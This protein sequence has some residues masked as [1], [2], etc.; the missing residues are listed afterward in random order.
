MP[1]SWKPERLMQ[2]ILIGSGIL[3]LLAFFVP[4][5]LVASALAKPLVLALLQG[6]G[7]EAQDLGE[8]F[9]VAGLNV[10]WTRDCAGADLLILLPAIALWVTRHEPLH[11]SLVIRIAC[12][13]PAAILANALRVLTLIGWRLTIAPAVESPQVHYFLGLIWLVPFV[14]L[15]MPSRSHPLPRCL[16]DAIHAAVVIALLPGLQGVPGAWVGMASAVYLLAQSDGGRSQLPHVPVWLA[17]WV[18]AGVSIAMLR[19]ES[20]W[21]PWAL[22]FPPLLNRGAL[23]SVSG[24]VLLASTHAILLLL[25]GVPWLAVGVLLFQVGASILRGES[26]TQSVSNPARSWL[27][28]SA[29]L[30]L[31][32]FLATLWPQAADPACRPPFG[33]LCRPMK[34]NSFAVGLPGFP[35][36]LGMVWF[37]SEGGDRHHSVTVCMKYRGVSLLASDECP[38]VFTNDTH[39]Y[40]EFFLHDGQLCLSYARYLKHSFRP[41][42]SPGVHLVAVVPKAK[43]SAEAFNG[44]ACDLA[45][46]IH[47]RMVGKS[48]PDKM[49]ADAK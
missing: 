31:M 35:R 6:L 4:T 19:M 29:V 37:G 13:L 23:F 24:V 7:V 26:A 20:F 30:L 45:Q 3:A 27:A 39:W 32:P 21:L 12:M 2:R 36:S 46:G 17:L 1:L 34:G 43:F 44:L 28:W 22:V 16:L 9:V 41:G 47:Q 48:A 33:V 49:V 40:R 15:L 38:D 8:A 10:P 25:P 42:S 18:V 11:R 5:T 14:A